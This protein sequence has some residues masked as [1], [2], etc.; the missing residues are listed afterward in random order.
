MKARIG[1][2]VI[3]AA[4]VVSTLSVSAEERFIGRCGGRSRIVLSSKND[5]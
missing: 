2:L 5:S 1:M 3:V 4:L